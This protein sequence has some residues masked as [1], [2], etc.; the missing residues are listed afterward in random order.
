MTPWHDRIAVKCACCDAVG[1]VFIEHRD[2]LEDSRARAHLADLAFSVLEWRL[3]KDGHPHE[4]QW[5]CGWCVTKAGDP[6][7]MEYA[8]AARRWS[9]WRDE[10]GTGRMS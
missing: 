7:S 2:R 9:A 1:E 8:V 10:Y 4:R 3:M 5:M 6:R